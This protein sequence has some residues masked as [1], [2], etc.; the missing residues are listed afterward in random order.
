MPDLSLCRREDCPLKLSCYR[1]TATRKEH[2]QAYADF[3]GKYEEVNGMDG[4]YS[5]EWFIDSR[6]LPAANRD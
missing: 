3:R 4:A 5:C 6:Q 1:Y 2:W